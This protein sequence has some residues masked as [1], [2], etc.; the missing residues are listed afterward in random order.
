MD[1][2]TF[3]DNFAAV[4]DAPGGIR[5]LRKLIRSL[6]L[7]GRLTEQRPDDGRL[8]DPLRSAVEDLQ[9]LSDSQRVARHELGTQ[10]SPAVPSALPDGWA[11]L[12]LS[13][14]AGRVSGNSKLI[15]GKLHSE[16][17]S[18]RFQGFSAS[19]PD[20][21]LDSWDHEGDAIVVSAVGARCGKAFRATDRWSAIANTSILWPFTTLVAIDYLMLLADDEDSWLR[22]GGAQPFVAFRESLLQPVWL[23]P[24]AEQERIVVKVNELVARCGELE[25]RRERRHRA[26]ILLRASALHALTEAETPDDLRNA[27]ERVSINWS[28][29]SDHP[30]SVPGLR[31][32]ILSLA[33][34]GRLVP[35]L[36]NE[37]SVAEAD[38]AWPGFDKSKLW[39]LPGPLVTHSWSTRSMASLGRWG[40][41]GTPAK[42]HPE[43]YGGDI[44]WV[45]IGDLNDDLVTT[46]KDRI[47]EAGLNKSAAKWIPV[48]SVLIAMYGA[49]IGKAGVAGIDCTSNQAI[50]HCVPNTSVITTDYLFVLAR[51]LKRILTEAGKGAAQPNISQ[52]VLKH[53]IVRVPPLAQ[54]DLIVKRLEQLTRLCD[55][56]EAALAAEE[57]ARACVSS[58]M[59]RIA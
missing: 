35:H 29:L 28:A 46:T 18:E 58:G 12:R 50:A 7:S 42:S 36:D 52:Q 45:V 51:T 20:V 16:P 10:L 43:Y 9:K 21:W 49:S 44:P 13:Q 24:L 59:S 56:L 41:G 47:T 27:W 53:L 15:K 37:S 23:P 1:A 25:A 11:Q 30:D 19:G 31:Q 17:S 38:M 34:R 32:T 57:A 6:G 8:A 3:L 48:G 39:E 55:L 26:S 22:S 40:S 33:V 2:Q 5:R 54:Q 4:S 14:V